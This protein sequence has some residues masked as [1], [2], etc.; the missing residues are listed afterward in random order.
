VSARARARALCVDI[1]VLCIRACVRD[2]DATEMERVKVAESAG[3]HE[4]SGNVSRELGRGCNRRERVGDGES[5][6]ECARERANA[7]RRMC[8][9]ACV[10]VSVYVQSRIKFAHTYAVHVVLIILHTAH[11]SRPPLPPPRCFEGAREER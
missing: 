11:A 10:Y 1:R 7:Y 4:S 2:C 8:I 3:Q 9:D 6:R 5:T